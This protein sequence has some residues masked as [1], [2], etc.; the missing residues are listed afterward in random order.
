M[1]SKTVVSCEHTELLLLVSHFVVSR[2]V[3]SSEHNE[4]LL[5]VSLFVISRTGG[6]VNIPNCYF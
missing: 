6:N 1:V 5:S 4:L 2:T 3:V